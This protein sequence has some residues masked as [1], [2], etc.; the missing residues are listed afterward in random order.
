VVVVVVCVWGGPDAGT[1]IAEVE[2]ASR[3]A[4]RV[5]WR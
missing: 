3:R 1:V 5:A 4:T 2:S